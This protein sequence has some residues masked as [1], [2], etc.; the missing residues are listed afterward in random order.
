MQ[1]LDGE[2]ASHTDAALEQIRRV[3][4]DRCTAVAK[5]TRKSVAVLA[6]ITAVAILFA[7]GMPLHRLFHPWGQILLVAFA[8]AFAV[9]LADAAV[10]LGDLFE[11]RKLEC[12]IR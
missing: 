12:G 7:K 4:S 8:L 1:G 3:H 10:L 9:A 2:G 6:A 5:K 11:R